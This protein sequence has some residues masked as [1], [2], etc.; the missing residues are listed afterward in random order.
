VT[1]EELVATARS[2]QRL[3]DARHRRRIRQKAGVSQRA[4]A[5]TLEVS[6]L[7]VLRWEQGRQPRP[8][9]VGR[10]VELLEQLEAAAK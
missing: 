5:A 1:N 10:Y 6:A 2:Y 8:Y 9:I 7:T 4:M 3:P